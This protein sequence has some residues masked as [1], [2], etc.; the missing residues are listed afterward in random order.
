[1]ICSLK[2]KKQANAA[3][4]IMKAGSCQKRR[5]TTMTRPASAATMP[6]GRQYT[7][8]NVR[9]VA[10]VIG[11]LA[12][13]HAQPPRVRGEGD[14]RDR[15][16]EGDRAAKAIALRPLEPQGEGNAGRGRDHAADHRPRRQ[17]LYVHERAPEGRAHRPGPVEPAND[18]AQRDWRQ[19]SDARAA[20]VQ[21]P[22]DEGGHGDRRERKRRVLPEKDQEGHDDARHGSEE[23]VAFLMRARNRQ[24]RREEQ[25]LHHDFRIRVRGVEHVGEVEHQQNAR[26][27]RGRAA[28]QPHA[29]EIHCGDTQDRP[30]PR[31][32]QRR[33]DAG[34]VVRDRDRCR[35]EVRK[36]TDDTAGIRILQEETHEPVVE[37]L[38]ETV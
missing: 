11:E 30:D 22:G 7:S 21:D 28:H 31:D 38:E 29:Q 26:R 18:G 8:T 17:P 19:E 9:N 2:K 27:E 23:R 13:R 24:Q 1:M 3:V 34:Q 35:V 25:G 33:A 32:A 15:H 14:E 4:T 5:G 36:L 12:A 37:V 10:V 20:I 6:S 16:H